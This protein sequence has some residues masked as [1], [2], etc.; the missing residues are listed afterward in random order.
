MAHPTV[1]RP[2]PVCLVFALLALL[3][4]LPL[5]AQDDLDDEFAMDE[6]ELGLDSLGLELEVEDLMRGIRI[7]EKSINLRIAGG[8]KDN[9]FPTSPIE[10]QSSP[11][12]LSALDLMVWRLPLDGTHF[13]FFGSFEDTRYFSVEQVGGEQL[14]VGFAQV[15]REFSGDWKAGLSL[16]YQYLDQVIDLIEHEV[17]D[18]AERQEFSELSFL[19]HR[20][21]ARPSLRWDFSRPYW[22]ELQLGI[23]RQYLKWPFD[24]YWEHGPK[25]MLGR[26]FGKQGEVSLSFEY[27]YRPHDERVQATREGMRIPGQS[28]AMHLQRYEA[29]WRQSWDTNRHWRT[30][31]RLL[32]EINE[33][34][35]SGFYDFRRWQLVQELRYAARQWEVRTQARLA[36]TDYP[37]QTVS[38]SD[39]SS[40]RRTSLRANLRAERKVGRAVKIFAE[41]E[42]DRSTSRL[43]FDHYKVN[44]VFSGI[45]WEF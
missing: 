32:F 28:L 44:T 22:A 27:L 43:V 11:L 45:D 13:T 30:T 29:A 25:V 36:Y 2:G 34:N 26:D 7:W 5:Q 4:G 8:Y 20:M 35:G 10:R 33:D 41:Y 1:K 12:L 21:A 18:P 9:V 37:V 40:R 14:A 39:F 23:T 3:A 19:G 6:A 16:Q 15:Q 17:L 24:D 42:H 31:T 38:A